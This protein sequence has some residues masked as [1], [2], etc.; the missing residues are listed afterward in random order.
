M[1]RIVTATEWPASR[2]CP[3]PRPHADSWRPCCREGCRPGAT[4][5]QQVGVVDFTDRGWSLTAAGWTAGRHGSCRGRR[6][7]RFLFGSL[8]ESLTD[9][10]ARRS[11]TL[12]PCL[13]SLKSALLPIP[14]EGLPGA[15]HLV[16]ASSI[17]GSDVV[18]GLSGAD[19]AGLAMALTEEPGSFPAD[20]QP[21]P[22]SRPDSSIVESAAVHGTV[23]RR[24]PDRC[25]RS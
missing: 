23:A 17:V 8:A 21:P 9:G 18:A 6:L 19:V 12:L 1:N 2:P 15:F 24:R 13:P 3:R 11:G 7:L 20:H 10:I 14:V 25:P 22:D 4:N 16:G 5:V